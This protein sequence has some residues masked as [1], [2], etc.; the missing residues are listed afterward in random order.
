DIYLM[1]PLVTKN[2]TVGYFIAGPKKS[3]NI[4]NQQD[5][6]LLTIIAN[7][8][9]VALQNAQRFEE[10]QAFN[11]TLQEKVNE[12]TRELKVTNKK[13]IALDEAKDEFISMAS[14]QLR[15]PLT[16]IK[17]YLSM[18]LEGD[19]GKT[20]AAQ[21]KA[22]KEAFGSS[23]RMVY[24]ISDFLNVS[25]IKTGKFVIEP[26]EVNLPEVVGEEIHQLRELA[27]SRDVTLEYEAPGE[28]P[29]VKLDDN[30]I[31][32]VMM[33]MVD[34]AIYYTPANGTVQIQLYVNADDVV[35]KV[36]DTGIGVPKEEQHKLFTKFFRAGNA[37]V[38]RPD[39]TGLG[40]FMAQKIIVEQGGSIIFES[41]EGK[42][43]TFGFRFPL[44]SIKL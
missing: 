23:Q 20:S 35:F 8:L 26:K 12:A 14:H 11:I 36:V 6:S 2:E 33:N 30:K 28:F 10:I 37:R 21:T 43:S 39:G 24:L 13:L 5:T 44:K 27:E 32:Q 25:R 29:Q 1:V 4:Y 16:S 18:M 3:G 41:T 9:A 34:N 19:L 22:I 42:G 40:L 31:R 7:E 17:G 38:A 15:T